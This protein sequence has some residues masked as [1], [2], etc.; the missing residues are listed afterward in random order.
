MSSGRV[1]KYKDFMGRV[2][3]PPAPSQEL[4]I[5]IGL[6]FTNGQAYPEWM[7]LFGEAISK[8]EYDALIGKIRGYFDQN[9]VNGDLYDS[10]ESVGTW[11]FFC[12]LKQTEKRMDRDLKKIAEEYAGARVEQIA[13]ARPTALT[14]TAMAFDQYGAP[15]MYAFGSDGMK[16]CWPPFG[17][18]IVLKAP[19]SFDMRSIWPKPMENLASGIGAPTTA[20]VVVEPVTTAA[21]VVVTPVTTAAPVVVEPVATAA[22][23][24]QAIGRE[25]PTPSERLRSAEKLRGDGLITEVEIQAKRK[26]ILDDV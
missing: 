1:D 18:N 10:Y 24:V 3:L 14:D 4:Y 15:A 17:Y 8:T 16:P 5:N 6:R 11:C 9:A 25:E 21:P 23:V 7:P 26:A 12:Y 2:F 13:T 22:P 19:A 20:R